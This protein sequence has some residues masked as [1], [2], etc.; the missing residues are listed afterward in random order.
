[1]SE[2]PHRLDRVPGNCSV[3]LCRKVA[4]LEKR[5]EVHLK[6]IRRLSENAISPEEATE[7]RRQIAALIAEVGTLRARVLELSA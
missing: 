7:L 4:N 2:C 3:C 6:L 5:R 1:M